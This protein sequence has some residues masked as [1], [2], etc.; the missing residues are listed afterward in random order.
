[1][2]DTW[3]T[4]CGETPNLFD[5]LIDMD[6]PSLP[7]IALSFLSILCAVAQSPPGHSSSGNPAS[8]EAF[9]KGDF[10]NVHSNGR[11]CATCHVPEESFQLTPEHVEA[12]FQS[13]QQRRL[14]NPSADD[15]LFRPI[16][17][18]DGAADFTNLRSH[19]LVRVFIELPKD[20]LGQKLVWP[21]DDP[22]ATIV[23]VWRSTPTIVNT[24][25]TAPYQ[26][27]GRQPTLQAQALGALLNHSEITT[28]PQLRFLNDVAAFQ[29]EQFSSPAV[30]QL[31]QALANG[32]TPPATDPPLNELELRGKA[33]FAHA[34]AV[35]HG[36]PSQTVPIQALPPAIHDIHISKPLPPF[37]E[38]LPFAPSPIAPRLWAF[39][40]PGQ[41]D[42]V[43]FPQPTLAKRWSQATS[44]SSISSIFRR[45]TASRERLLTSTTIARPRSRR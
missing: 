3:D 7:T 19:A 39:R 11:S 32:T 10:P 24:A 45:S 22:A 30:K 40:V 36:G 23:S 17:A 18:N 38:D 28:L 29:K 33:L 16:D 31:S 41:A 5:T 6:K 34:C 37:A 1:M 12:R 8:G 25:F 14:K 26:L 4:W 43:I 15:P 27:D 44:M 42:P 2:P 13:L 21:V 20:S 9:F 35:C